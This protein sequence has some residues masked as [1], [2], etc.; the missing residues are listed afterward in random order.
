MGCA[1]VTFILILFDTGQISCTREV[2]WYDKTMFC[3]IELENVYEIPF[4]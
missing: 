3:R 4:S 1:F 2:L